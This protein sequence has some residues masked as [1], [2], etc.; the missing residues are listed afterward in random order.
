VLRYFWVTE[1]AYDKSHEPV[2]VPEIERTSS[3]HEAGMVTAEL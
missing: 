1:E 3:K 2:S